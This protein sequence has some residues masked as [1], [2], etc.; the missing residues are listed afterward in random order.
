M[1]RDM[2]ATSPG[3]LLERLLDEAEG[4]APAASSAP[5]SEPPPAPTESPSGVSAAGASPLAAL[6]TDPAVLSAL[7]ALMEGLS[8]LSGGSG[9]S[10]SAPAAARPHA[11]DRHTALLC[12]VKP[13]LSP[14]RRDAAETV[15]RLCRIWDALERAGIS[16][17]GLLGSLG[18]GLTAPSEGGEG[19]VQ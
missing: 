10:G 19:N 2:N 8:S 7:P 6:L 11:I 17:S 4:K 13:Y 18:G 1:T 9:T 14:A 15:I 3:A 12:A 16:P 5:P